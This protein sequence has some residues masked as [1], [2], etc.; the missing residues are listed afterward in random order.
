MTP[1]EKR[2]RAAI[3]ASLRQRSAED[4]AKSEALGARGAW[5][6]AAMWRERSIE[7][8]A[9]ADS[10]ESGWPKTPKVKR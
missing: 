3:V 4:K 7:S 5:N 8:A 6:A 2:L 1:A 10:I 9:I